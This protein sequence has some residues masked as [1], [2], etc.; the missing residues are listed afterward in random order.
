VK[1]TLLGLMIALG[2]GGIAGC[3]HDKP[4]LVLV[5]DFQPGPAA[6]AHPKR[7]LALQAIC[8]SVEYRCPAEFG[9]TADAIVRG[10]LEFAGY[11][12]VNDESLRLDTRARHEEHVANQS[13]GSGKDQVVSGHAF[14]PFDR[15][16]TTS[17]GEHSERSESSTITLD[18]SGFA[19]LS[20]DERREVLLKSGADAVASVRVVVGGQTGMWVP[21]QQVEV[22][23]KLGANLGDTM[24]WASR[25][26]ASSNDF[27]TVTAALEH[28][29]RCA[30]RG[31]TGR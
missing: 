18:G 22:L 27:S 5:P 26:T 31:A 6:D 19:D 7:V 9:Q 16:V 10:G 20:V 12:V 21:N 8:G 4:P 28:A 3:A 14:I 15:H 11:A 29:A 17:T 25:C 24:A 2:A 1:I 13:T 30:M 23:V